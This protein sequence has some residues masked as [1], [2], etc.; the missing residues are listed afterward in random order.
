MHPK[1]TSYRR[2]ILVWYY[3]RPYLHLPTILANVLAVWPCGYTLYPICP[4]RSWQ[5]ACISIGR[6]IARVVQ[7]NLT[8]GLRLTDLMQDRIHPNK[9]G[10]RGAV[11]WGWGGAR[12][13]EAGVVVG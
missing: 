1:R 11:G 8:D 9:R 12:W 10:E 3:L 4:S 6:A 5:V 7:L 2:C 13:G